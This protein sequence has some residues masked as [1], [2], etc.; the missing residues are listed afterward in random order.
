M[1]IN[2]HIIIVMTSIQI[3][4][5]FHWAS[6]RWILNLQPPDPGTSAGNNR[7]S[8]DTVQPNFENVRP[9]CIMVGHDDR[10]SH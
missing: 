2:K 1:S 9:L 7:W 8:P 3:W 5:K 10:T 4:K 6:Q